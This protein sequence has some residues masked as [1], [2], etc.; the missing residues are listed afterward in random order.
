MATMKCACA[1]VE[2]TFASRTSAHQWECLC[3]DCYD[4][5]IHAFKMT[6]EALPEEISMTH[7]EGIGLNLQY[8]SSQMRVNGKEFIGFTRLREGSNSTNMIAE[9]CG[10]LMCVDHPAYNGKLVL[11][12]PQF[13]SIENAVLPQPKV[14]IFIADYP[15]DKYD[16]LD[17]LP[18]WTRHTDGTF[19]EVPRGNE[20]ALNAMKTFRNRVDESLPES[21]MGFG[22]SFAE[23]LA[24]KGGTVRVLGIDENSNS[25]TF[26]RHSA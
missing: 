20:D 5:N 15:K 23:L 22:E 16:A 10:A 7:G 1:K 21:E 11:V 9:C 25:A 26:K 4:K 14:R 18:A 3:V 19:T 2:I 24:E 13:R 12:F 8:F 6:G 17:P